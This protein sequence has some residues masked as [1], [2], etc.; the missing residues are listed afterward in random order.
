MSFLQELKVRE[1]DV[2]YC[3]LPTGVITSLLT[4][5]TTL[6]VRPCQ[7]PALSQILPDA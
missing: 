3:N 6:E 2:S 7:F 4:R 1:L 5:A